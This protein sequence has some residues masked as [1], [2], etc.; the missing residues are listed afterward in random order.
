MYILLENALHYTES[1]K[2]H[3]SLSTS[4]QQIL[5][6]VSD[7]GKGIE[8][9]DIPHIFDR[10][11]RADNTRDRSGVGLGLSIAK[12]I[13]E[14]HNGTIQ[15]KSTPGVGTTFLLPCR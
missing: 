8:A 13:I 5:I 7:S 14:S 12:T 1:G 4:N 10:F 3:V 2:I 15:V 9:K 6:E 11:Y